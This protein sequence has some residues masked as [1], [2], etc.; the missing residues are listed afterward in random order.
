MKSE[1]K[2]MNTSLV[3]ACY[4]FKRTEMPDFPIGIIDY[5]SF[6]WL[7]IPVVFE[8]RASKSSK[9]GTLAELPISS[10][11]KSIP[12]FTNNQTTKEGS[13]KIVSFQP[14]LICPPD[15]VA[16]VGLVLKF[17]VKLAQPALSWFHF[18][19]TGSDSP[20]SWFHI[21]TIGLILM[22]N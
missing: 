6:Q 8:A 5:E 13:S 2:I 22:C 19:S 17:Q 15:S 20:L 14:A 12:A 3:W 21:A 11:P 18:F 16:Y 10:F 1:K 9:G 7:W 4:I